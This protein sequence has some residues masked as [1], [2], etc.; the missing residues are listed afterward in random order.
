MEFIFGQLAGFGM[1][2]A[3]L[4]S[5][6]WTYVYLIT[7]VFLGITFGALP[8]L[9]ATLAVTILTGFFGNK[10]PLDYALIALLGAYV[11]AIYGGSYPSIL[12]N[13]PGTAASAATAM[14]GYPLAKQ[15]RGAEALGLTTT[16]SFIGTL[17]GTVA[18]L[19]FVWVLLL[20]S[21]N[22]ASPEK[23]LLALFG[24]LLS[25]TLMSADLA[26]KG[27]IAGLIGL[28]LAM[29]GMDPILSEARYTFGW[30]YLLSGIAVVPVLMGAFAVPQI[31]EGMRHVRAGRV[32]ELNGRI[33][34][35]MTAMRRYLPTIGR[36][37]VIGTG[38]GALPGVGE[39]VAGWVSYGVGKSVS[40]EGDSFGKGSLEG[41]L[42][43]ETANNACI[44]GALI[45][46]LVLGIPGSPPAAALMGAF[47]INNVIPGPT[48]DPEIILRVVAIMV[49]A[50]FTM[51]VLGLFTARIFIKVLRIP[52][53]VFLPLVMVLTTIG[54]FSVGGGLNDLYLMLGVGLVAYV[55]N[56][57]CYPIAPLVI[58]VILGGMFDETFRRS[59]LLS[60]G[61]L[62]VFVSRPGAA[63][64]L[65]LIIALI[66]GQMPGAKR[67][68][69]RL[70]GRTT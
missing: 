40:E 70:K 26:I 63:L 10:I 25:G 65:T 22:I 52:Q 54:S 8:G 49:L 34:P 68:I 6:P 55:M 39:D 2:F 24:I 31:I 1:A 28:A 42:C 50:S 38:V 62:S 5:D 58:G 67:A 36:S 12:L 57:L 7:S 43:S 19:I 3:T 51:F 44:G 37:G 47:K 4:V 35:N 45:P 14:D 20:I 18:L 69:R 23:A 56:L 15:G 9:T 27:W 21:K 11:G 16:A 66:L 59:L 17:V 32:A 30:S 41:L 48:I 13:I 61:D 46:L 29:V 60:D 53:T 64:L 33:L